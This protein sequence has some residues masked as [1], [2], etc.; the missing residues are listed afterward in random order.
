ML[1]LETV[2]ISANNS[3][4]HQ[5]SSRLRA[6]EK[7]IGVNNP[8]DL[9]VVII[10]I[11]SSAQQLDWVN[12]KLAASAVACSRMGTFE[13]QWEGVKG[14]ERRESDLQS[15]T[16]LPFVE[17]TAFHLR[18]P[19]ERSTDVASGH[20]TSLAHFLFAIRR[21]LR[22]LRKICAWCLGKNFFSL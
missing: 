1:I 3:S 18:Q 6:K 2:D 20:P 4:R 12:L 13:M 10:T 8:F 21:I 19:P 5:I 22:I 11:T 9:E 14:R 15:A 7:K 16:C 17:L